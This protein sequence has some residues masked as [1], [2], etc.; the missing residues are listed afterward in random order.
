MLPIL[1]KDKSRMNKT[2]L[3]MLVLTLYP[4][5][6][7]ADGVREMCLERAE[8]T[9]DQC[10]CAAEALLK[11]ISSSDYNFYNAIIVD[12][13]EDP[14]H[15]TNLSDTWDAALRKN[16]GEMSFTK[17]LLLNNNIGNAH[18]KALEIKENSCY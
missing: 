15:K 5:N 16:M 3:F 12:F 6:A 9:E 7:Y 4:L 17:A 2:V 11:S 18:R 1:K 8:Y 13:L 10:I 14:A